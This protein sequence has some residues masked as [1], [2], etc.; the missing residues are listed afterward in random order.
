MLT[1]T[2][3]GSLLRALSTPIEERLR[4]LL[5]TRREQLGD[6]YPLNDLA[7]FVIM[8][9]NDTAADVEQAIGFSVFQ[10]PAD[11]SRWGQPDFTP[12]WEWLEDHGF[13][14]ELCFVME[15]SGFGHIVIVPKS[16][17]VDATLLEFCAAY[18]AEHA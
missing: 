3:G 15:D 5:T 17:G 1:I 6:E 10:N 11:G 18:A 4:K 2:D 13:A 7:K 14:Y 16:E 8:E 12:G 9:P